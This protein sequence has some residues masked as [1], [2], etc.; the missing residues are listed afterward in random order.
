MALR[1]QRRVNLGKGFGLNVS[2][3]GVS[4]SY[5]SRIGSFGTTGF[6]IR[7]GIPGL[8]FRQ[9]W[10]K[11]SGPVILTLTVLIY[12][13]AVL[14]WSIFRLAGYLIVRAYTVVN[15]KLGLL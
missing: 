14:L 13:L 8:S 10:G 4:T 1:Y 7:T 12:G 3:S 5:R 15:K 6:S 9:S 2:K 11:K